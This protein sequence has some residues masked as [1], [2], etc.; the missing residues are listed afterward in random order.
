MQY[1]YQT[2]RNILSTSAFNI[3]L[4]G[5]AG[6]TMDIDQIDQIDMERASKSTSSHFMEDRD[7]ELMVFGC[8]DSL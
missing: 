2:P 7:I 1:E 4:Q 5:S 6:S 3:N 8:R